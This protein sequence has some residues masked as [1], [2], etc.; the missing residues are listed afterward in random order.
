MRGSY[1]R[2]MQAAFALAVREVLDVKGVGESP[3]PASREMHLAEL[4]VE[5]AAEEQVLFFRNHLAF[6]L[7]L[8][9]EFYPVWVKDLSEVDLLPLPEPS[10]ALIAAI[11]GETALGALVEGN[12]A[13]RAWKLELVAELLRKGALALLPMPAADLMRSVTRDAGSPRLG[14]WR[15]LTQA[16]RS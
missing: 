1:F 3:K 9:D 10:R 6:S 12:R 5:Q 14:W 8:L 11:D 2:F 7:N 13:E 16:A 4:L 15:S